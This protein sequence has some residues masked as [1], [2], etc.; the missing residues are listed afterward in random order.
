MAIPTGSG[1]GTASADPVLGRLLDGRYLVRE[2]IARGGMATVYGALDTRLDRVVA[3]KVMHRHLSVDA[4]FARRLVR[5][6]QAAARLNHP[7]V[8][9]VFDQGADDGIVFLAMELVPGH[10]LR[11][12][13][14]D[15]A[16]L[17]P[18]RALALL[19]RVAAAL[20]AAHAAGIVHRDV[21]PEN[22]LIGSDGTVKVADFGLAR[23][24]EAGTGHS[25]TTAT[26]LLVGTMSYLAPELV[27]G[28]GADA[29]SD[30]YSCG[31]VAYELLTGHKPHTGETPIQVAYQHVHSDVPPPSRDPAGTGLPDYVD[32]PG[33]SGHR[34]GPGPASDRRRGAGTPARDGRLGAGPGAGLGPRAGCRLAARLAR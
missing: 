3:V 26:G 7:G 15:E 20:A 5:E 10:T 19:Q 33:G 29:R 25:A 12:V 31:I 30:V 23:A 17:P 1:T 4:D 11:D 28:L 8:V 2:R 24:L 13:V 18:V 21:K 22:V 27:L 34:P 14:R 16:P 6:A 32:A 9:A